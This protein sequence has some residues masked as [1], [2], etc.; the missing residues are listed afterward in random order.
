MSM[1]DDRPAVA[2][3]SLTGFHI[4]DVLASEQD[5]GNVPFLFLPD[6][7]YD[8]QDFFPNVRKNSLAKPSGSELV[9]S[10]KLRVHFLQEV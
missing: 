10:F 5:L 4:Q 2:L 6:F 8:Q 1:R 3:V 7:V 9:G